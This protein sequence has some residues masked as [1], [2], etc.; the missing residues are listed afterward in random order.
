[1][2]IPFL[3]VFLYHYSRGV[4]IAFL[5]SFFPL[6][7][8]FTKFKRKIVFTFVIFV[9]LFT[10]LPHI[11]TRF[12]S[13]LMLRP[14]RWGDRMSLWE[15]AL[16]IFKRYPVTGTGVGTYEVFVYKFED[17]EKFRD[18]V[19]HLHASNTYLEVLAETGLAGLSCLFFLFFVFFRYYFRKLKE[20]F[21]I[22]RLALAISI[23]AVLITELTTSTIL[24]GYYSAVLFWFFLGMAVG[25]ESRTEGTV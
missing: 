13:E 24:I 3:I 1:M 9:L 19:S 10:T 16:K 17:R 8:I 14:V 11:K 12:I 5:L 23:L 18:R 7:L 6:T 25:R 21:D 22:Y 20:K 2:M 4:W 15:G